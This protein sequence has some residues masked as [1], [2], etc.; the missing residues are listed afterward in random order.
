LRFQPVGPALD[1]D[2]SGLFR[3]LPYG[4]RILAQGPGAGVARRVAAT[5]ATIEKFVGGVAR[6][7]AVAVIGAC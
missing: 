4:D 5:V 6:D 3:C 2:Q 7:A 1:T